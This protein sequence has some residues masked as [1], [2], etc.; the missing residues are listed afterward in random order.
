[1]PVVYDGLHRLAARRLSNEREGHTLRTTEIVHEAYLRL[2]DSDIDWSDR[3][4][5]YAIAAQVMWR[6][7]IDYAKSRNREKRDGE[8][9]KVTA[10]FGSGTGHRGLTAASTGML[11][12]QGIANLVSLW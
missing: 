9:E 1:M 6:I 8:Y 10:R 7:L 12:L 2:V 4:H 11:R 3:G 5:F